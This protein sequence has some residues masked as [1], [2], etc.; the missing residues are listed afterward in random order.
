MVVGSQ[1]QRAPSLPPRAPLRGAGAGPAFPPHPQQLVPDR[2]WVAL[3]SAGPRAHIYM[4]IYYMFCG[5]FGPRAL[6]PGRPGPLSSLRAEGHSTRPGGW[7]QPLTFRGD[8]HGL[9]CGHHMRLGGE[10]PNWPPW[11]LACICVRVCARVC[12]LMHVCACACS[13]VCVRVRVHVPPALTWRKP[14]VQPAMKTCV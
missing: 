13:C 12:V 2:T 11:P 10:K 14:P 7:E 4:Y 3:R 9:Q 6:S 5:F 1:L 8:S